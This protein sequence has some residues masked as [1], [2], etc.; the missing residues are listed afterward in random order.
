MDSYGRSSMCS[1]KRKNECSNEERGRCE[2]SHSGTVGRDLLLIDGQTRGDEQS[3][4]GC[5]EIYV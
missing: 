5:R 2:E 3:D 4:G 1:K